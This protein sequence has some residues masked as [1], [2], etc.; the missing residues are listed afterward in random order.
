VP[1]LF[2]PSPEEIAEGTASFR[3]LSKMTRRQRERAL[4]AGRLAF[5][6]QDWITQRVELP[7]AAVPDLSDAD[8]EAAAV[9]LRGRWGLGELPLGNMVHLLEAK[10]VRVFSLREET[11]DVDA[12]SL[13][14]G[15]TPYVFLNTIKS[16]E[17]SRFDAAHELGHLVLHRGHREPHGRDREREADRFAASFLMPRTS[18]LA[19]AP[20]AP[21]LE[22]LLELRE[23]WAVS[24]VALVH[25]LG[26]LGLL[27]EWRNRQLWVEIG[28][29]GYRRAEPGPVAPRETSLLLAKVVAALREDHI[30]WGAVAADLALST[31]DLS[32]LV[33]GL[34]PAPLEGG[35]E[36]GQPAERRARLE[37]VRDG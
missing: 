3:A 26:S 24:L 29:R 6:L 28:Q 34:V 8:P 11:A 32:D 9:A 30:S 1:F 21:I 2:G 35:G 27:T 16:A 13:W 14:R 7:E 17:R 15:S 12:F 33:F 23:V 36:G 22:D 5:L 10:G 25:R 37:L 19:L 4:A 18:V 20:P 31:H